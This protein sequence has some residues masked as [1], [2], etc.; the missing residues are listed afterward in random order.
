MGFA[1]VGFAQSTGSISGKVIDSLTKQG[2]YF[3]TISIFKQGSASPFNGTTADQNGLFKI[4]NLPGGTY[5]VKFEFVGYKSKSINISITPT[6]NGINLENILLAPSQQQLATVTVTAN[7]PVVQNKIDK[8][9]YNAANDISSQGGVALDILRKVPMVSVDID[10][11]VELQGD[12][13]VRFLINGKPS[14]IFGASL[15]DAL[16]TIPASQ[17][18]SIEVITAPGAKYDSEGTAGIINI[19]LKDS[20]VAGI[21]GSVN[22]SAGT[23]LENTS[24]NLNARK[25]NLGFNAFFSGND[26]INSTTLTTVNRTSYNATRDTIGKLYQNGK[27]PFVRNGYQ[28]GFSA[29]WR[30]SPK[31]ELTATIGF[32]NTQNHAS[33]SI[34][35]DEQ[36]VLSSGGVLYNV[37]SFRN[38]TGRFNERSFD[39]S[40]AYKKIFNK[41]GQELDL[42]YTTSYGNNNTEASQLTNYFNNGYPQNG[43]QSTNPGT[44][45]ET[46][47]SIDYTQPIAKGFELQTGA[48]ATLE[49]INTIANT[50]TLL[51]NGSYGEDL[52]QSNSFSFTRN[53]Y[54][55]YLSANF[56]LFKSFLNGSAGMRYENTHSIAAADGLHIPKNQ[57]WAPALLLQHQIN[58]TESIKFA[59]TFRV[60]RP[61]YG[62]LNPFVIVSDPNNISTG[63]PL[64]QNE[65]NHKFELDYNQSFK[66]GGNISIGWFY[67]YGTHDAQTVTFFLPT[68]TV[69]GVTYDNVSLTEPYNV[70][71]QVTYGPSVSASFPVTAHFNLRGDVLL[72]EYVNY[73]P[74]VP[75]E[76]ALSYKINLNADYQLPQNLVAEAFGSYLSRREGFDH[77]RPAF[78]FY[79]FALRKQLLNKKMGLGFTTTNPFSPY[80][81]QLATQYGTNFTQ[82]NLRL[83]PLRSFGVTF[84]YKFGKLKVENSNKDENAPQPLE[85]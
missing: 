82:N 19:V 15:A 74:G 81:H 69:N 47:I 45:H 12:A 41:D 26:Q 13:N 37:S 36:S 85:P 44:D 9:V 29:D 55:A 3:S 28:S 58:E 60:E 72:K 38:S 17:I 62:D 22:L 57:L 76:S 48:K 27:N 40:L 52:A 78:F 61:D 80:V 63:N 70:A 79:T 31:D 51:I 35:Q 32:S 1:A 68:Y 5:H 2:V 6:N 64:L 39:W 34:N 42:L 84:S 43:L 65:L 25:G 54:A 66:N 24:V 21:N 11:N 33:G 4:E 49:S 56:K 18:K 50:D 75:V 83:V 10:G 73:M 16:Q 46:D 59:Y 7:A 14:S 67:N 53:I 8:M 30:I 20:K 71:K 23:R 77:I